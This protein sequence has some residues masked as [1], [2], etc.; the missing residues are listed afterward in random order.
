MRASDIM[1]G[2]RQC[3]RRLNAVTAQVAYRRDWRP[4][5]DRRPLAY[6]SPLCSRSAGAATNEASDR[7][8]SQ[9]ERDDHA[10]ADEHI[11]END[12]G[13]VLDGHGERKRFA[14]MP[15][16]SQSSGGPLQFVH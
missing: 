14:S 10:H 12:T 11:G 13:A 3:L 6:S 4:A 8:R 1:V 2:C 7:E 16:Y 15:L 5:R 9:Q